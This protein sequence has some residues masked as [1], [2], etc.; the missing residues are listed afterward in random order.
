MKKD[1][2]YWGLCVKCEGS[3][4]VGR[5]PSRRVR[6]RYEK[7]LGEYERLGRVGKE[8]RQPGVHYDGCEL[9]KGSG[10]L[11]GEVAPRVDVE[12][13]PRVAIVG[14]GIGGVALGVACLHRGIPFKLY[15]RDEGFA[16]RSQGYGLTLQ[17]A[18]RAVEGLGIFGFKEGV[19]SK[20]HVVHATDGRV[21]G[22]WGVAQRSEVKGVPKRVN[23]HV[24]RQALRGELLAELGGS[25]AVSWG[26]EFLGFQERDGGGIGLNFRVGGECCYEEADLLVGADGI[27]SVVRREALGE[28]V[29]PLR[30]L[31][32]MVIL[33]ICSLE[34]LAG[35]GEGLL[36]GE[37]VFQTANGE[38]RIYM[39]PFSREAVMWQMSFLVPEEEAK[40]LS[41]RGA[42]AL[43]EEVCRRARWHEPIPEI[44]AA[45]PVEGVSGYPVYDREL[46]SAELLEGHSAVTLLGD[47][48]HPMSP[49]KGQGANQALLDALSLAR[50]LVRGCED[51]EGWREEGLRGRILGNFEEEMWE[52]SGRKVR[53]SAEA[54]NFLHSEYVLHEGDE[55]RGRVLRRTKDEG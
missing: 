49:F 19:V 11:R 27:R 14:A 24:A 22:E 36:D 29:T 25:G 43:K 10:L 26:H 33:G 47:A 46:L 3:G 28:G 9:C 40:E 5:R 32:C 39:M 54:A 12:R 38:E 42:G 41:G 7:A 53:D 44:L 17:Q 13:Y 8:P 6:A 50:A 20:R 31:G 34:S 55:P 35:A 4:R 2:C 21:L 30:Y 1:G 48:A 37:T 45:T 52:R 16:V 23:V 15:E 51:G 18:S